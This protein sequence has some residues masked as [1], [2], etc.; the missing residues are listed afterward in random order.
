[1]TASLRLMTFVLAAAFAAASAHAADDSMDDDT[2]IVLDEDD[3]PREIDLVLEERVTVD[4]LAL[5]NFSEV[6]L[7]REVVAGTFSKIR[8][9]MNSLKLVRFDD[10]ARS[11]V[12]AEEDVRLNGLSKIDIDPR[13]PFEVRAGEEILINI[14]VDLDKSI[15]AIGAGNSGQIGSRYAISGA[16]STTAHST[17]A[18]PR[19]VCMSIPMPAH[20]TST[21][22]RV[23]KPAASMRS[24]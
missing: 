8:L 14:D 11:R 24:R 15:R 5:Q 21:R 6:L 19:F 23:R 13:G 1:V 7:R 22:T 20:V 4:F 12:A 18:P 9:I 2:V 17:R 3:S 10:A 16:R